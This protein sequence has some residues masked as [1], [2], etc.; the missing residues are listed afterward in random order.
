MAGV[1]RAVAVAAAAVAA[2]V[3]AVPF[4]EVD[5]AGGMAPGPC[6]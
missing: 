3:M 5:H 1:A 2:A 6:G 4:G